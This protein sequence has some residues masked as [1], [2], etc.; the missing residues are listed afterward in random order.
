MVDTVL[1][2]D[3]DEASVFLHKRIISQHNKFRNIV[4][5]EGGIE[6]LEYLKSIADDF[7]KKPQLIFLDLNMPVM[8]GWEFI[9]EYILLDNNI[10]Q[11][12]KLVILSTST[13]P[14]D[15]SKSKKIDQVTDFISK[16][17]SL[18]ALD[19]VIETHFIDS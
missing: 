9:K 5:A 8:N 17:L 16:P 3:D 6:G 14:N 15:I 2:I 18:Q 10:T 11:D 19:K 4:V 7:A 13:D 1:I 12:I